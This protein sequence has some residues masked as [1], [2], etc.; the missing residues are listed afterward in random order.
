MKDVKDL[1]MQQG[2][3][4][5][6]ATAADGGIIDIQVNNIVFMDASQIT[7]L[8]GTGEGDGGNI[9]ID[10]KFVILKNSDIRADAFGGKGGDIDVM[11]ATADAAAALTGPASR[12]LDR[13]LGDIGA[14]EDLDTEAASARLAE[15]TA[16]V[17]A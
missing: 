7:A 5:A 4:T 3:I 9:F 12:M 11:R 8:V 16:R 6:Q 13:A 10:P 14:P 1:T 15:L 17:P 2:S